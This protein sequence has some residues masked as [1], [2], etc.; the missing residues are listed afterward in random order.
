MITFLLQ[1]HS[2]PASVMCENL[3]RINETSKKAIEMFS[4]FVGHESTDEIYTFPPVNPRVS[5]PDISMSPRG[6]ISNSIK[7]WLEELLSSSS[8]IKTLAESSLGV[9]GKGDEDLRIREMIAEERESM[10]KYTELTVPIMFSKRFMKTLTGQTEGPTIKIHF[11]NPQNPELEQEFNKMPEKVIGKNLE[12]LE[13]QRAE[14]A[15]KWWLEWLSLNGPESEVKSGGDE[16]AGTPPPVP[17]KRQ[18]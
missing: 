1:A 6:N 15:P 10:E 14:V 16:S 7:E 11:Q 5:I 4:E 18:G 9:L 17:P 12:H 13:A 8:N 2:V 3:S